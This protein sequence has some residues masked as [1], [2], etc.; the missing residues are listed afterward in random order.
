[1]SKKLKIFLWTL[2]CFCVLMAGLIVT[3]IVVL[4]QQKANT[5]V[6]VSLLGEEEI[7]LEVGSTYT[8]AG[9][10]AKTY[11]IKKPDEATKLEVTVSGKVNTEKI[12]DYEL[13]YSTKHEGL[14][15]SVCRTVHVVDTQ[16]PVITLTTNPDSYTLPGQPYQE[17]G[18]TAADNYDGDL[19]KSVQTEEKDGIVYYTVTDSSG[20]TA[21]VQR[22]VVYDDPAAPQLTLLGDAHI[23]IQA[24]KDYVDAG[25]TA[26]DNVKGDM[27]SQIVVSGYV[28]SFTPGTYTLTFSATDDFENTGTVSRTVVVL[29]FDPAQC[30]PANG[31]VIYLTFDDGPGPHTEYLLDVLAKYSVKATFFVVN[32]G[33]YSTLTRAAAEGHTVAIHTATHRFEQVYASEAAYFADLEKMQA[34]IETHTG[35]KSMLLRFP[36]G[37]SNTLSAQYNKGIMTRLVQAVEACGYRYF[38]WNVDSRDAGGATSSDAVFYNVIN[39]VSRCQNS[40]V[41]QHD[42]HG[43]SVRAVEKIIIWGLM[44][45]YTFQPIT[46]DSPGA[47]H[48]V[49]N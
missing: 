23:T 33:Y 18:F 17:E 44:N 45:G 2:S 11:S 9:A 41:L 1:M 5:R 46:A 37:S 30:A 36:G 43:Y 12:G 10:Q 38:D 47:H 49:Y 39:G 8:D 26:V 34:I 13:T 48:G 21:T 22:T 29:P 28:D 20:N 19:T 7:T 15:D 25:C 24:G 31:K 27:T 3:S 42:I 16:Q 40:V 4:R 6:E 14:R 32:N 35:I